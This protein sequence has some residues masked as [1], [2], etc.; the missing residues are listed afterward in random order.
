[1]ACRE[2]E[3]GGEDGASGLEGVGGFFE[4]PGDSLL[5]VADVAH[6]GLEFLFRPIG[7]TK[8]VEISVFL[9][10]EF[11][12]LP[13]QGGSQCARGA[14]VRADER[15]W[16]GVA[17]APADSGDLDGAPVGGVVLQ[18]VVDPGAAHAGRRPEIGDRGAARWGHLP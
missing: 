7:V 1:V 6:P 11:G 17:G 15:S 2:V 10:V 5:V 3:C 14:D 4:L 9:L 18:S 8:Q 13:P 12:E 16:L